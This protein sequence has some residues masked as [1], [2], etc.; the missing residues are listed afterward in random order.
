MKKTLDD[1]IKIL[2]IGAIKYDIAVI[3]RGELYLVANL[4]KNPHTPHNIIVRI[5]KK[6]IL[7]LIQRIYSEKFQA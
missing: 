3:V 1:K 6:S 5:T 7:H 4:P 2:N